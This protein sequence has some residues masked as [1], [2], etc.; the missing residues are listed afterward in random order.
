MSYIFGSTFQSPS[1][2]HALNVILID[3]DGGVVSQSVR[4]ALKSNTF[5]TIHEQT[6]SDFDDT[7]AINNA[8]RS[9][10][11][12]AA[13][14]VAKNASSNLAQALE[15]GSAAENHNASSAVGLVCYGSN[16]SSIPSSN[17]FLLHAGT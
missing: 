2:T 12:W 9:G 8:I 15:G 1:K 14:Y 16:P 7:A 13:L 10:D 17:I 6:A 5:V 3:Y 4:A 11:Y